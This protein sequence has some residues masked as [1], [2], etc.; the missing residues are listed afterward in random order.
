MDKQK[1]NKYINEWKKENKSRI[2]L[3]I[4]KGLKEKIK[5]AA[6]AE[7]MGMNPWIEKVIKEKLSD[8]SGGRGGG[9][10]ITDFCKQLKQHP[11]QAA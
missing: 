3:E 10:R 11:F 8:N 1:T 5:E 9:S 7:N 2:N 6:A 4:E